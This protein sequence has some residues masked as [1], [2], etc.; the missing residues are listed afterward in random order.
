MGGAY[1]PR[2][3]ERNGVRHGSLHLHPFRRLASPDFR[4]PD[5]H[6]LPGEDTGESE[7]APRRRH[8]G[9]SSGLLLNERRQGDEREAVRLPAKL[10][11][12][13]HSGPRGEVDAVA[14]HGRRLLL[15]PVAGHVGVL[16][17][18]GHGG[19][20]AGLGGVEE[21]RGDAIVR[22]ADEHHPEGGAAAAEV[23]TVVGV[24]H[25]GGAPVQVVEEAA[26]RSHRRQSHLLV[27]VGDRVP[28]HERRILL[29]IHRK[30]LEENAP[31]AG[32]NDV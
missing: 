32:I 30:L 18:G 25:D 28:H 10:V 4:F 2:P 27:L 9:R 13:E 11:A 17:G 7:P 22:D 29:D 24:A 19:P 16:S 3:S 26:V 15:E 31:V 14:H 21:R 1:Q 6:P 12:Q 8:E 20:R 5:P 23:V